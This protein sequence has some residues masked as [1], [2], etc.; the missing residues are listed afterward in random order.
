V[1]AIEHLRKLV[2]IDPTSDECLYCREFSGDPHSPD[3]PWLAAKAWLQE[4]DKPPGALTHMC[5]YGA[6][7]EPLPSGRYYCAL[8]LPIIE[9]YR[10][11]RYANLAD[12]PGKPESLKPVVVTKGDF[13]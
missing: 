8:H 12:V 4:Q 13:P 10:Q 9:R 5:C 11:F 6:C 3:C 1:E 7:S 2:A